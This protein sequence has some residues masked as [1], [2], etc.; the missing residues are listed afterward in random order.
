MRHNLIDRYTQTTLNG[1]TIP[2]LDPDVNAI[3]LDIFPTSIVD[4][5]NVSKTASA[6]LY[7]DFA[8]GIVNIITK[9][10]PA[11]KTTQIGL[12]IDYNPSMH[13]NKDFVLYSKSSTD[14]LGFFARWA[15][16]AP[17]FPLV[18]ICLT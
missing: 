18:D 10:F 1:L 4:N 15:T 13:F 16:R 7:G 12:G 11:K 5:L 2:G 6:D 8:G 3:Q 9:K 17:R 14:W